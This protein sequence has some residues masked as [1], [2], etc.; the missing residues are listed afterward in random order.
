[1]PKTNVV[2]LIETVAIG[3]LVFLVLVIYII[4]RQNATKFIF[5]VVLALIL[6]YGAHLLGWSETLA[7]IGVGVTLSLAYF[8][9]S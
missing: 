3:F 6:A 8:M 1:L 7:F 2:G 5:Q 4:A 9:K